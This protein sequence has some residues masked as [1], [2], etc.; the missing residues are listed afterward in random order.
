LLAGD[1]QAFLPL[2]AEPFEAR[3]VELVSISSLSL[4]RFDGNDYSVPT[5]FAYQSLTATG[6]IDRVRFSHR[7]TVVAEHVRCWGKRQVLFDPLHYLALLERKPGALDHAKPL[8]GWPLPD[9]FGR[10]RRR[11]EE[12]DPTGGTRRYIGVLRLLETY[13]LAAV[14]AAVER[15]LTLAIVDAGAVRLLLEQA[16]QQPVSTFDLAGRPQLRAVHLPPPDLTLYN[17][18]I[19][20]KGVKP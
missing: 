2:P 15:A 16:R 4:G 14:A 7:G 18:L 1:R 11:L 13:A 19:S 9:C 8:A 10:L 17:S 12:A 5:R 6:T 20:N 3:R